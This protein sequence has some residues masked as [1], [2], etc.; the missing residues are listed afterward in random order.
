MKTGMIEQFLNRANRRHLTNLAL[1]YF[2]VAAGAGGVGL[3]LLLI[4][5]RQVL[6]WYWPL[7]LF[8]VALGAG[9]YRA[10]LR[11]LSRYQLA[12]AVDERL[13]LDDR[14]STLVFLDQESASGQ[15]H[16]MA[17][18]V[19]TQ[20]AERLHD[21]EL[22]RAVPVSFP[23][24]GYVSSA[25]LVAAA[26]L[27]GVRYG[28]L[29]TMDLNPPL[30]NIRFE[31][32]QGE[33][34]AAVAATK[35]SAIQ[36]RWEEQLKQLGI[37][38]EDLEIPDEKG[39]MPLQSEV[40]GG[41]EPGAAAAPNPDGV[42]NMKVPQESPDGGEEGDG[43]KAAG[44]SQQE[45]GSGDSKG[46]DEKGQ[47]G[48]QQKDAPQN[49]KSGQ[50]GQNQDGLMNKMRDA[51]ANLMNKL[52][53]PS[54]QD[55]QQTA[56]NNPGKQQQQQPGQGKQQGEGQPSQDQQGQEQNGDKS[57]GDKSK[58][59]DKSS[60][61]P[62]SQ[63][64]KSGMGQQDGD[65]SLREAQQ[66]AAMGKISEIIGKRQQQVTGEMTVEVSSGKQQLKTQWSERKAL[67]ADTGAE[68]NRNEIPLQ[69]QTYIQRYFEEVRK[70]S[71]P[72]KSKVQ[73]NP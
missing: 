22:P 57:A 15:P 56:Q 52:K 35:K 9:V 25:L 43:D 62:G 37:A 42:K 10:R 29:H 26:A 69:Y 33:P 2:A 66:L 63:D 60:D 45:N 1:E 32:L 46:G 70:S 64:S 58:S 21:T 11:V 3:I 13:A 44:D 72:P 4:L 68:S 51:V 31:A 5:G 20:A 23:R 41:A 47:Q 54:K 18:M 12:Q 59:G 14:L 61:R 53:T 19:E 50:Q 67:H 39:L 73:A 38:P 49:A 28:V 7:L 17:G 71:A 16:P 6:N 30:A 34:K 24:Y 55:A 36:E 48:K 65:K 8:V 40:P 27:L